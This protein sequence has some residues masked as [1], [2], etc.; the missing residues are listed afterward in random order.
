MD[1]ERLAVI[2]TYCE[3][4]EMARHIDVV[5]V[6]HDAAT[7]LLDLADLERKLSSSTAAVYFENP[8]YLG[9]IEPQ[10]A[11]I[12][13]APQPTRTDGKAKGKPKR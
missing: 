4:R 12:A 7:G 8:A 1:P 6:D 13:P 5:L 3:P 2:R 11:E 10:A 9:L